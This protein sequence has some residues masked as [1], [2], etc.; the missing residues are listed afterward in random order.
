[1]SG[2]LVMKVG[3]SGL[4]IKIYTQSIFFTHTLGKY[5]KMLNLINE[6]KDNG[7]TVD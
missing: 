1:M 4:K 7:T 5:G 3:D 6:I 2:C